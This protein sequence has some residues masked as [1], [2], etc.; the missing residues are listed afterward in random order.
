MI[1]NIL[2]SRSYRTTIV[3]FWFLYFST[4]LDRVRY[5]PDDISC[6][7]PSA[8]QSSETFPVD[9]HIVLLFY[10]FQHISKQQVSDSKL[11]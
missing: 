11:Y 5:H 7:V 2:C 10:I 3:T 1:Y 4:V 8:Y 9:I 6:C